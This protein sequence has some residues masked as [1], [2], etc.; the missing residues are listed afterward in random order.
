[1]KA[2]SRR[3]LPGGAFCFRLRFPRLQLPPSPRLFPSSPA[4]LFSPDS[5]AAPHPP[6]ALPRPLVLSPHTIAP[7]RAPF[8]LPLPPQ[9]SRACPPLLLLSFSVRLPGR[10]FP[11]RRRPSPVSPLSRFVLPTRSS[12]CAAAPPHPALFPIPSTRVVFPRRRAR[13]PVSVAVPP[14]AFG[15]APSV[16]IKNKYYQTIMIKLC[17]FSK[18]NGSDR[19]IFV[20]RR[21]RFP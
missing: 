4:S 9:S 17:V 10:A 7:V 12:I 3:C 19:K 15:T 14:H 16:F 8:C 20:D 11:R 2:P 13:T 21:G 5:A 6:S 1:M 18:K